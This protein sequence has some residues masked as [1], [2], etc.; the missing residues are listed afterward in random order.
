M[1]NT[2]GKTAIVEQYYEEFKDDIS[3]LY[4]NGWDK[5]GPRSNYLTKLDGTMKTVP[6]TFYKVIEYLTFRSFPNGLPSLP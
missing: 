4:G 5:C 6:D 2:V 1:E 3:T